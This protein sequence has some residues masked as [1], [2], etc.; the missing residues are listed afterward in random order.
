MYLCAQ[1]CRRGVFVES[2]GRS[3]VWSTS[4]MLLILNFYGS[5]PSSFTSSQHTNLADAF[6]DGILLSARSFNPVYVSTTRLRLSFFRSRGRSHMC[7]SDAFAPGV[8]VGLMITPCLALQPALP[9][10]ARS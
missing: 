9:N 5:R 6:A 2:E 7:Q 3:Q 4:R 10:N 1:T 8:D